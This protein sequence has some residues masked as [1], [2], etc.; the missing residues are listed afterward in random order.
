[1]QSINGIPAA[2]VGSV[3]QD[4]INDGALKVLV[5]QEENGTYTVS[6]SWTT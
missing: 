6:A 3:V 2:N 4:F 1:M 5:E